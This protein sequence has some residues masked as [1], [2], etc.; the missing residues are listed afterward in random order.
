MVVLLQALALLRLGGHSELVVNNGTV[1]S[2]RWIDV[3]AGA[4]FVGSG[5]VNATVYNRGH[6][7][8]KGK[9]ASRLDISADYHQAAAGKLHVWL[10]Q[11]RQAALVIGG[12]AQ[13]DGELSFA[14]ESIR[15][16]EVDH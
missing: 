16:N 7:A 12:E 3:D 1:S 6:V 10:N 4:K 5:S 14:I 9:P 8:V 15:Y 13:L 11:K 2:L